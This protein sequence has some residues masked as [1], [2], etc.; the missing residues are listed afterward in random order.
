MGGIANQITRGTIIG[1]LIG[2]IAGQT[3]EDLM[4]EILDL[5]GGDQAEATK[6][7]AIL[8]AI[9]DAHGSGEI[10]IPEPPRGYSGEIYKQRLNYFHSNMNDGKLWLSDFSN[11]RN[12][13]GR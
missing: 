5:F 2:L 3:I 1:A 4:G 11:G 10:L 12:S 8:S 7:M 13:W 6:T 9:E